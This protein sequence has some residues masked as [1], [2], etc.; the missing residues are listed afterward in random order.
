MESKSLSCSLES[1]MDTLEAV[2]VQNSDSTM[3][4]S[5]RRWN[6]ECTWIGN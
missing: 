6:C 2:E 5:L 4:E 3:A 1:R